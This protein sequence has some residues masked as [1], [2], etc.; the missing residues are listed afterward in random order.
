MTAM[1]AVR[2]AACPAPQPP[3]GPSPL[4]AA[5]AAATAPP[6]RLPSRTSFRIACSPFDSAE[7]KG[8]QPAAKSRHVQ[9]YNHD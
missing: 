3:V 6:S 4:H 5:R 8:I 1:F 9:G 7:R 2:S